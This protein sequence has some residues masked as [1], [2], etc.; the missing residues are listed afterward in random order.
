MNKA[1]SKQIVDTH[2]HV[3]RAGDGLP[4]LVQDPLEAAV[5]EAG[6]AYVGDAFRWRRRTQTVDLSPLYAVTLARHAVASGPGEAV[7]Q[8]Q[9]LHL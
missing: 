8:R 7:V 3:F 1:L 2:F 6:R 5:A 9:R 4:H